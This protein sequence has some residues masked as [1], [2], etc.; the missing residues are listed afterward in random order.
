[1]IAPGRLIGVGEF[2]AGYGE[3]TDHHP[4]ASG[5]DEHREA[6]QSDAKHRTEGSGV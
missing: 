2:G 5:D 4:V 3:V 6:T 1:M